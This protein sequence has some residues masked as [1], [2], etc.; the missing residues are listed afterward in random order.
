MAGRDST[1]SSPS[2]SAQSLDWT[3]PTQVVGGRGHPLLLSPLLRFQCRSHPETPSQTHS[4][5]LLYQDTGFH[6]H[7]G[8]GRS[9][10]QFTGGWS[11]ELL[12][13]PMPLW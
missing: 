11:Q 5:I 6:V 3:M 4:G 8:G 1:P 12:L 10:N 2:R 13:S 7:G 9:V